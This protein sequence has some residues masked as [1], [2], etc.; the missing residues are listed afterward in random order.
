VHLAELLGVRTRREPSCACIA[1]G[2][3]ALDNSA[4]LGRVRSAAYVFRLHGI[5]RGDVVHILDEFPKRQV[6]KIDKPGLRDS[7]QQIQSG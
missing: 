3:A 7:L 1:D 6:G 5:V 4:F 2:S